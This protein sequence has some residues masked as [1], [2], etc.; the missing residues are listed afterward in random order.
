MNNDNIFKK[1]FSS[2]FAVIELDNIDTDMLIPKQFLKTTSRIGLG[3]YLFY[4]KR[5][6]KNGEKNN[7]F[8][9]NKDEFENTEIL[10]VGKNFG[11]GSSREHAPWAIKDFG[12]KVIIAESFADIF[13]NNCF[14][15]LILPI[16]L[17]KEEIDYIKK[18]FSCSIKDKNIVD[19]FCETLNK[20]NVDTKNITINLEKQQVI[21]GEKNFHFEIDD[22]KKF[23]I[24]NQID[25]IN[26]ILKKEKLIEEFELKND[27]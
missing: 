3:K 2:I 13:Y 16:V 15:N 25:T 27:I 17:K 9:L 22:A 20:N 11:C 19:W 4:E 6:N 26:E 10:V 23:K 21:C 12:I 24:L 18:V 1:D 14:E 5:Y 7:D 8:I